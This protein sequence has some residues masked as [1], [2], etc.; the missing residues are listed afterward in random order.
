[1]T[2]MIQHTLRWIGALCVAIPLSV[3]AQPST[4]FRITTT[5]VEAKV[6]EELAQ[7][8][9]GEK[10]DTM[11]IG[12]NNNVV[13]RSG[14]PVSFEI[15]ALDYEATSSRWQADVNVM[16][17]DALIESIAVS[18]R[19][20]ELIEVPVLV[21]RLHASDVIEEADIDWVE[22][23]L[24]RLR[25]DTIT[26]PS[27]LYGKAPRRT[28]SPNRPIRSAEVTTPR[29]M[30]RGDLVQMEYHTPYMTIR[31]MGEVLDEAGKGELV[32]VR[33]TDSHVIVQAEVISANE[34][35]ISSLNH[36]PV[37]PRR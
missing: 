32:R 31:T 29:V 5:D 10:V 19:Y 24:D 28:I 12:H 15:A 14:K 23:P 35:R 17:G 22:F 18:G 7:L 3:A 37:N 11:L 26:D 2:T 6:A 20:D 27:R 34:V 16:Y 9:A 8:G 13:Y 1:M 33:N 30:E 21:S 4:S 36:L 25:K